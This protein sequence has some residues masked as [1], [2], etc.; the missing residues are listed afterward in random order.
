[1]INTILCMRNIKLD[2]KMFYD[3]NMSN[4]YSDAHVNLIYI[5]LYNL[6]I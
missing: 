1:M 5:N 4:S 2:I 3:M 6:N